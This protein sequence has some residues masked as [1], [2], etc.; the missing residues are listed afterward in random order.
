MFNQYAIIFVN[1]DLTPNVL[2]ALQRQL[3]ITDTMTGSEFD[4]RVAA[5]P[6]YP[7]IAHDDGLQLLVIRPLYDFTNRALAD[8]V[9]FVKD[10]MAAVEANKY[11]PPGLSL[12]VDRLTLREISKG[13]LPINLFIANPNAQNNILYELYGPL[14][15]LEESTVILTPFGTDDDDEELAEGEEG[16]IQ[17][18]EEEGNIG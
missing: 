9:I 12:P 15:R 11:G 4:A 5:D 16:E 1:A 18:L 10:G 8:V 14:E 6:N 13:T 3:M 7:A 2:A 17:F